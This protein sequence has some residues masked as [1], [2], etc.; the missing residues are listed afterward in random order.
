MEENYYQN[1]LREGRKLSLC[2]ISK[3]ENWSY[4]SDLQ[5]MYKFANIHTFQSMK[6]YL[7]SAKRRGK[8]D[9]SYKNYDLVVL[10]TDTAFDKR[11]LIALE[12]LALAMSEHKRVTIGY[13]YIN[14]GQE[15]NSYVI[16]SYN[17][18]IMDYSNNGELDLLSTAP[19]QMTDLIA[20]DHVKLIKAEYTKGTLKDGGIRKRDGYLGE[21]IWKMPENYSVYYD[22]T[23]DGQCVVP[24]RSL[25]EIKLELGLITSDNNKN[26]EE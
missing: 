19:E 4:F 2:V 24:S 3:K 20:Y 14:Q 8:R 21:P 5:T 10:S 13:S 25:K 23:I 12:E 7:E 6:S 15:L 9:N 17:R 18:G 11:N 1:I 22:A 26:E 16:E